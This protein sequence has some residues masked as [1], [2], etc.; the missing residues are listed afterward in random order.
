[1]I[2]QQDIFDLVAR[3]VDRAYCYYPDWEHHYI[4][5]EIEN[6]RTV[7]GRATNLGRV[8]ISRAFIGTQAWDDLLDTVRHE[9]AHL[10]AGLNARHGPDWRR[11][12]RDLGAVPEASSMVA[13]NC[14]KKATRG[15]W[16]LLAHLEDGSEVTMGYQHRRSKARL[17][18]APTPW[19]WRHINGVKILRFEYIDAQ[20]IERL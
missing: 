16:A 20:E 10:V 9:L 4:G 17:E 12:A 1:M 2:T 8:K 5:V 3:E 18:Y 13:A 15:R 14:L 19:C 11:V 7:L 6:S